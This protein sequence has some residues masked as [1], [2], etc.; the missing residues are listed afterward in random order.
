MLLFSLSGL[1]WI[2]ILL[3]LRRAEGEAARGR[4]RRAW[5]PAPADVGAG[6]LLFLLVVGFFWRT[7]SGDVFQPADGGD[8]VSF[9]Y[10]TWRFAA[11]ELAGGRLP[12][13]NPHL[14]SGMPLIA[15]IQAGFLYPPHLIMFL[16]RPDFP[17]SWLQISSILHLYWAGLGLY[18][19]L[20][21]LRLP[22]GRPLRPLAALV[23]ALA[24]AFCDPLLI[25][26]GNL[27][28]I[29]VLA[30]LPWVLAAFHR[31]LT[32][33]CL[34]WATGAGLLFGVAIL[35]G[36]A[37][38]MLFVDL[39]LGLYALLWTTTA[40]PRADEA[41][42]KPW[43]YAALLLAVTGGLAVLLAAPVLL[44]ALAHTQFT[45]RAAFTYQDTVGYSLA[46]AQ[47]IG[48]ITPGFF[49][50]GPAL[51][52]GLWQRVELPYVGVAA[53]LM[54]VAALLLAGRSERRV[55]LPWAGIAL[56]GLALGFGIYALAHGWLTVLLPWFG[57]M[58][59]PARALVLWALGV[60]VLA[61]FG[62]DALA[63]VAGDFGAAGLVAL[64]RL[65]RTGTI[66]LAGV[67]LP[68][69]Y[70]ALLLTQESETAF[71][72]ASLATLALVWAAC[73]W[74]GTWLLVAARTTP[75]ADSANDRD[76]TGAAPGAMLG[77]TPFL[78]LLVALLFFD[79]AA[80]GAYTDISPEDPTRGFNH[81]EIV[82][83]LRAE[84]TENAAA[85]PFRIDSLT[86]IRS[87][88]QPDTAALYGLE[89]VGGIENPLALSS[90]RAAW[91]E[92][93]GRDT[94]RYQLLNVRFVVARDDT[95]LPANFSLALDAPGELSLFRNADAAPRAFL[96]A[97]QDGVWVPD[98]DQPPVTYGAR[99]ANRIVVRAAPGAEALLVFSEVAYPGWRATVNGIAAPI[100][101][102]NGFQRGVRLPAGQATVELLFASATLRW[103][104]AAAGAGLLGAL[105]VFIVGNLR[106]RGAL[107]A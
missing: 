66:A 70:L 34:R 35:A 72:R 86:D 94:A 6:G 95:P 5:L 80:T 101:T 54:A 27:N 30:W 21:T 47:L 79:L 76:D 65:L 106:R 62:A 17:Y 43:G 42:W 73:F 26:L 81:P 61:G 89:D 31:A 37:Q 22:G 63:R 58:R 59:A 12:L 55:L 53:L 98:P 2:G 60:S 41:A 96:A 49:G 51:H 33:R 68:L 39:A 28:L 103:G 16:L 48:L 3:L 92:T 38:S 87:L 14:Y 100:E 46:P 50:R 105:L 1:L 36:H 44:P 84:A 45:E 40:L 88:W 69:V 64:R 18:V 75:D 25:H 7:L 77:P 82:A 56:A 29:A 78:A 57:Q 13:W 32:A 20:R 104:W 71:L 93:G 4:P 85:G 23:G 99:T 52:W 91:E 24:F 67:A 15:D 9:L 8:L 83:F 97:E 19:L 102:V 90:W 10:P 11:G 74:A 107:K